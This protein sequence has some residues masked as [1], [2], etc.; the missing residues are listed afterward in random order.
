M[1]ERQEETAEVS[2]PNL[3]IYSLGNRPL[4]CDLPRVQEQVS[5]DPK[6]LRERRTDTKGFLL[7]V[8]P[9]D[10]RC[11]EK[12]TRMLQQLWE[13]L[14][15]GPQGAASEG[16]ELGRRSFQAADP[17]VCK[18]RKPLYRRERAQMRQIWTTLLA[19]QGYQKGP[20]SS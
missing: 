20:W 7:G 13:S 9:L 16:W 5:E 15:A 18:A 6:G 10:A 14:L 19:L 12:G 17:R 8:H 2:L 11:L 4:L 3:F 1:L